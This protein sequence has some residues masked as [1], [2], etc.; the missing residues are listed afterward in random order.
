VVGA[1]VVEN[2]LCGKWECNFFAADIAMK[3]RLA[4]LM[5][6]ASQLV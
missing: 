3:D 6:E 5:M 4:V 1:A 2:F